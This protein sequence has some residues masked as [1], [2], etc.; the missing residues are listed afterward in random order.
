MPRRYAVCSPEWQVL[1]VFSTAGATVMGFGYMLVAVYLLWSLY[2]G[3]IASADPWRAYWPRVGDHL[4][5]PNR[6]LSRPPRRHS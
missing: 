3:A 1:N 4:A 5:V 6:K 2:A